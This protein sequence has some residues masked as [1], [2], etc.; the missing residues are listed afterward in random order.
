MVKNGFFNAFDP[1]WLH[2]ESL[3]KLCRPQTESVAFMCVSKFEG[4][5]SDRVFTTK[6]F[7]A[8]GSLESDDRYAGFE[9]GTIY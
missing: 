1:T 7:A 9:V 2:L 5:C 4:R 3:T 6:T 8:D